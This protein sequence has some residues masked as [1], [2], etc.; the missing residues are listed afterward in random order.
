VSHMPKAD[1][2]R[3][4]Q[5]ALKGDK[6]ATNELLQALQPLVFNL[7]IRMVVS[8]QDAEDVAQEV[9]LRVLLHLGT[10]D[11]SKASFITW[12]F[13]IAKRHCLDM[14]RRPLEQAVTSFDAYGDSL[15]Q[16]PYEDIPEASWSHPETQL[17]IKEANVGCML[18]MLLCLDREQRMVF[19]LGEIFELDHHSGAAVLEVTPAN[20][21]Q[22]LVRA[23]QDLYAFM[24]QKCG[25]MDKANPCRC[26]RKTKGFIAAGWVDPQN[27][28]FVDQH[29]ENMR[30]FAEDKAPALS[31]LEDA[32]ARM[33]R[34]HPSYEPSRDLLP[35]EQLLAEPKWRDM[36][37][38]HSS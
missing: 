20:Y 13:T 33:F 21:R 15:D 31:E 19:I 1:W 30:I 22:K 23:R 26:H 12:V 7:A 29:Y 3:L 11:A 18:G 24:N 10:F 25:L 35:I 6:A 2:E 8:P 16:I 32:Y 14:R 38:L 9:M 17:L 28:K 4:V 27:L 37:S 34:A 5:K 36:L